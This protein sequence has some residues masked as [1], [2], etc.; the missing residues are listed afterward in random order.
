MRDL[1]FINESLNGVSEDSYWSFTNNLRSHGLSTTTGWFYSPPHRRFFGNELQI[2]LQHHLPT[3][4]SWSIS[5]KKSQP[6][7]FAQG[8]LPTKI[9]TAVAVISGLILSLCSAASVVVPIV[10]MSFDASL[11]KSL[12]TVSAAVVLFSFVLAA[13]LKVQ[14]DNVF[15]ATATYAA[16]LVVF[17]GVNGAGG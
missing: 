10:I 7:Y 17:V 5:E 13:V 1:E 9:S 15:I 14:S 3:W 16:V 11:R 12:I 2:F 4:L 8:K 6:T